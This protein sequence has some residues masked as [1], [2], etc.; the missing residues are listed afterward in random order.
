VN[1]LPL[2]TSKKFDEMSSDT[3][4]NCYSYKSI[5]DKYKVK[6]AYIS[7]MT[8]FFEISEKKRLP[9]LSQSIHPQALIGKLIS[10]SHFHTFFWKSPKKTSSGKPFS[11]SED[12]S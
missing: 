7:V 9:T 10:Q 6:G 3:D 5:S 4:E 8:P 1:T 12:A 11:L 2:A